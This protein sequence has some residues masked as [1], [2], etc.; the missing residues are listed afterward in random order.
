MW[1]AISQVFDVI[2][3]GGP[4]AIIAI[5]LVTNLITGFFLYRQ[6][7]DRKELIQMVRDKVKESNESNE[8]QM[9][10][11]MK[12]LDRYHDDRA[13]ISKSLAELKETLAK[14]VGKL[15]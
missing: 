5:L 2:I 8:A 11:L 13:A 6:S 14:I 12:L 9:S 1:N 10:F 4:T 15:F 3:E 7:K